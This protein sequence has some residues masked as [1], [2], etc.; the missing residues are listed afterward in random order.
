MV[1]YYV[2][3]YFTRDISE[4]NVHAFSDFYMRFLE[5]KFFVE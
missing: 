5:A 4:I 3:M 2:M 1:A